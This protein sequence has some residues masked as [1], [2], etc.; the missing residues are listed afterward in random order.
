M[1]Y[2][3]GDLINR[4]LAAEMVN[5]SPATIIRWEDECRIARVDRPG[6][7]YLREEILSVSREMIAGGN[8]GCKKSN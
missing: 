1:D 3:P 5:R 4:S 6:A 7:W 8:R 2:G